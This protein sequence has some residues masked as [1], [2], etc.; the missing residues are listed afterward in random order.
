MKYVIDSTIHGWLMELEV[1]KDKPG[2]EGQGVCDVIAAEE[3]ARRLRGQVEAR[4]A[5]DE[6]RQLEVNFEF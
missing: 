3:D 2:H 1:F 6:K 4:L 5:V